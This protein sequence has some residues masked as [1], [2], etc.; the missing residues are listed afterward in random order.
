[1]S[2]HF[3]TQDPHANQPQQIVLERIAVAIPAL[4]A[5]VQAGVVE[6]LAR[7]QPML[8]QVSI[9]SFGKRQTAHRSASPIAAALVEQVDGVSDGKTA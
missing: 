5:F 3:P 4:F 8:L 7:I 6:Q 9:N 1:L 2:I